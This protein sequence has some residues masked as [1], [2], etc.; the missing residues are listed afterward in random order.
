M[1]GA[2]GFAFFRLSFSSMRFI[3]HF[4]YSR[5]FTSRMRPPYLLVL[6]F[7]VFIIGEL[8]FAVILVFA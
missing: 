8:E 1:K 3:S 5:P 7:A 2:E 4:D 6:L